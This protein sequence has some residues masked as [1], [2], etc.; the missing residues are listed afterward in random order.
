MQTRM[1]HLNRTSVRFDD[2]ETAFKKRYERFMA[3][4]E[5]VLDFYRGA[6]ML[7]EVRTIP[8]TFSQFHYFFSYVFFRLIPIALS[9]SVF[10]F[11]GLVYHRGALQPST[12][13]LYSNLLTRHEKSSL[14]IRTTRPPTPPVR[15]QC[16]QT[17]KP[18]ITVW[19]LDV[20]AE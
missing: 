7:V 2:N 10:R 13:L 4:A 14:L 15:L 18:G 1:L 20:N 12:Y 16:L 3:K 9:K 19:I 5:V 8:F 6:G 17:K 11:R